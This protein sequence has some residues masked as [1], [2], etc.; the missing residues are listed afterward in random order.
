MIVRTEFRFKTAYRD[1]IAE[2][3][4]SAGMTLLHI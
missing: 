4:F 2:R 3:A 1:Y